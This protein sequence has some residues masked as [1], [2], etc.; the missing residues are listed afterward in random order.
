MPLLLFGWTN[1]VLSGLNWIIELKSL[2]S[3]LNLEKYLNLNLLTLIQ[4]QSMTEK[5]QDAVEEIKKDEI[6][7]TVEV[8]EN[9]NQEEDK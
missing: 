9:E 7:E 2:H 6:A 4:D 1:G 3:I 8:V 5:V